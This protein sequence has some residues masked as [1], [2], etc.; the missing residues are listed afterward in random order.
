M[1]ALVPLFAAFQGLTQAN[2]SALISKSV[3]PEKQ[4]EIL[5]IAS[6]VQA[7]AQFIPSLL[8]GFI[9]ASFVSQGGEAFLP[10]SAYPLLISSIVIVCAGVVF[11]LFYKEKKI[12]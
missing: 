7:L 4:G 2:T 11:N 1:F 10:P 6:S 3:K 9:A 8:S 5:G 12:D